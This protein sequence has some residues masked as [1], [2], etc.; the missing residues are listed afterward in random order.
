M[1][2]NYC[3]NCG[4]EIE[5]KDSEVCSGCGVRFQELF[6]LGERLKPVEYGGFW[7]RFIAISIDL[8]IV[9]AVS[10]GIGFLWSIIGIVFFGIASEYWSSSEV[11]ISGIFIGLLTSWVYF[12]SFES[13]SKQGTIGIISRSGTLTYEVVDQLT[14]KGIGRTYQNI[15]LFPGIT[16]LA[17][18]LLARHLYCDYGI[19]KAALFS[20][21]VRK[22][23]VYHRQV[24]EELIDFLEIE[25][26]RKKIVGA[27][28]YGI[29]K[30]VE[31]G[32]ALAMDPKILLLDEPTSGMN[33]EET[34]D[35]ARFVLDIKE[36]LEVT[37]IMV[38]HDMG[39]VMEIADEIAVLHH[40]ELIAEGTPESIKR[41]PEVIEA[42]L[43]QR[44]KMNK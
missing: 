44:P 19:G 11:N 27:L 41:N 21:S 3:P 38:E 10:F 33:V 12:A 2:P 7:T 35:I 18:M 13:S 37:V 23:E 4:A 36:E 24:L 1:T 30:R 9:Y 17:N 42:Y 40:G 31:L 22:K 39:M 16:V 26:V 43:T 14:K 25:K 5:D 29:Q 28:P 8:I 34:E 32:R 15:E 6:L 20:S